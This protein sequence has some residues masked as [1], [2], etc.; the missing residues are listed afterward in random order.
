MTCL[1]LKFNL[2]GFRGQ[3]VV[4][5]EYSHFVSTGINLNPIHM[6]SSDFFKKDQ[7]PGQTSIKNELSDMNTSYEGGL[8]I[9]NYVTGDLHKLDLKVK[10]MM[11][12]GQNK[13]KSGKHE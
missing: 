5:E 1:M 11:E 10:S 13:I 6:K 7:K 12:I 2:K 4:E 9:P 8:V 3:N